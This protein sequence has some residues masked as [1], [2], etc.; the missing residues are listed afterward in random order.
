[1]AINLFI[2]GPSGSGKSTQAKLIADNYDLTHLSMGQ[3]LRDEIS[4]GSQN[5][6]K[7][8]QY[9][10]Q[11]IPTPD[12]IVIP[13]LIDKL[14]TLTNQDFIIDGFPRLVDQGKVVDLYLNQV[15]FPISLLIHLKCNFEEILRRRL[16]NPDFQKDDKDRSDNT[17]QAIANRQKILY[18]ANVNPVLDYFNQQNKLVEI[19]GNR[20]IQ[21]IFDDICQ[22]I[23]DL[24]IKDKGKTI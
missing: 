19:D 24:L 14:G 1:M 3:I 11:G 15:G 4:T 6:L 5:G 20:P 9:I 23:N 7:I 10:D 2:I 21:P 8:K 12:D 18:E 16:S 13:L 22:K 17:P